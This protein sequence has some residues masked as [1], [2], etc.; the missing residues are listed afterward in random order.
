[1]FQIPKLYILIY[2]VLLHTLLKPGF[3]KLGGLGFLLPGL[4]CSHSPAFKHFLFTFP[5]TNTA[6]QRSFLFF[7]H[8]S[9]IYLN[10]SAF[11]F[12]PWSSDHLIS[13]IFMLLLS[14]KN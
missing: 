13:S 9:P 4:C 12:T 10:H 8:T 3:G 14:D 11:Y 6:I 1:M 2:V 7:N 5:C